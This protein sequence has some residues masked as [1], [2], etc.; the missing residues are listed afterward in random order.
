MLGIFYK[1]YQLVNDR[2][3]DQS[4]FEDVMRYSYHLISGIGD[5]NSPE[6]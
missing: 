6:K 3:M 4:D 1:V 2:V 5:I